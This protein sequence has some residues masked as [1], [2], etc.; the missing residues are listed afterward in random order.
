MFF[1]IVNGQRIDAV[2][3]KLN[4]WQRSGLL[5][6]DEYYLLLSC[7]IEAADN[8]ANTTG[9]YA[10]FVKS[11]QGNALRPLHLTKPELVVHSGLHCEA[12]QLDANEFVRQLGY[13]DVVYLDPPYNTRQYSSYYHVPEL[14]AQG[15]FEGEPVLRGKTGLIPDTD[16]KSKWSV[17]GECVAA[18][19]DLITNVNARFVML[20]YNNE[21]IIPPEAV[22]EVFS[23][24]G[25][26]GTFHKH[27]VDY[28]RYRSDRDHE[29][30]VYKS[31]VVTEFVY[32]MEMNPS[33]RRRTTN[34][35]SDNI[36]GPNLGSSSVS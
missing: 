32:T 26:P 11:W 1:T 31:D 36:A 13:V 4:E 17:A 24:F 5:S 15:W 14:L 6:A 23:E 25:K 7:L 22:E 33:P 27:A 19:R 20:S 21:G 34:S 35:W 28:A 29:Q 2:R 18:F 10:A 16:K 12:H 9:V 30:R 3:I 8:V